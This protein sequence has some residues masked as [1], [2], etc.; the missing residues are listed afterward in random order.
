MRFRTQIVALVLAL[1]LLAGFVPLFAEC[2][3]AGGPVGPCEHC[4]GMTPARVMDGTGPSTPDSMPCCTLRSKPAPAAVPQVRS[5]SNSE[6]IQPV[7][8]AH[9]APAAPIQNVPVGETLVSPVRG[10]SSALL[11]TFLI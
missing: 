10:S 1:V 11:C 9:A 4:A 2:H 3:R 7:V 5:G 8:V 6:I